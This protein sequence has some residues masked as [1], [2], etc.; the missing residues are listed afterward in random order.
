VTLQPYRRFPTL[1][2]LIIFSDI[3]VIPIAMGMDCR[4][5]PDGHKG[6]KFDFA[7]ESPD[8]LKRLNLKPDVQKTLGYVFDA[9]YLTRQRV[10]NEVPVIG[11][12]G[13]PWT[14]MGY[15][16]EGGGSRDYA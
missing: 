9:V 6:P 14:L 3:L 7:L 13:A 8:G 1:D 2:S 11:F 15:M 5:S 12:S 4:M 16:V 10:D